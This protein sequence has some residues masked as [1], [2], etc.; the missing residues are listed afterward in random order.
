[1]L[2]PQQTRKKKETDL[3]PEDG[4]LVCLRSRIQ[5]LDNGDKLSE[6]VLVPPEQIN[7]EEGKESSTTD[8]Q[9]NTDPMSKN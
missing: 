6:V 1:M 3:K 2:P 5:K 4:C 7:D 8:E 9:I